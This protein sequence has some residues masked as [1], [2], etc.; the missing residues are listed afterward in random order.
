DL[1]I[2]VSVKVPEVIRAIVDLLLTKAQTSMRMLID[3]V[4]GSD[5]FQQVIM[6]YYKAEMA[7]KQFWLKFLLYAGLAGLLLLIGFSLFGMFVK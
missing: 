5:K 7:R 2:A 4:A 1:R 6:Q 3:S